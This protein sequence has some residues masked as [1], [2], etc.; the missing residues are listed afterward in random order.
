VQEALSGP[1]QQQRKAATDR[2]LSNLQIKETWQEVKA[3][4]DRAKIGARWV[5]KIKRD[6]GDNIIK[7]K[8]RLV[9]KGYS[10]IPE[11]ILRKRMQQLDEKHHCASSWLMLP[12]SILEFIKQKPLRRE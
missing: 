10:Q 4:Q 9:A 3:P 8:A 6:A 7:N 5:S 11:S 12:P 1:Q 2:E